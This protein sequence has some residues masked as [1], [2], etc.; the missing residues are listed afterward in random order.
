MTEKL[1]GKLKHIMRTCKIVNFVDKES[2]SGVCCLMC[3]R[4]VVFLGVHICL[5]PTT[6]QNCSLLSSKVNSSRC[7]AP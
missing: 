7:S 4:H 3:D 2:S 1:K 5:V 6:D